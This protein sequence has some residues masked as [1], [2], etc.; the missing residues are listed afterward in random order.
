[1][2]KIDIDKLLHQRII[3]KC[4]PLYEDGYFPQ[5]ASESMKQ[6]ELAI[7]EKT[8]IGEKLFGVRLVNQVFGAGKSIKL[9]IPLGDEL[10]EQAKSLFKGAFSYYRNYAAHDGSKIDEIICIRVMVLAS[11]LLDLIG[12]SSISFTEIGGVEGLIKQGIFDDETQIADLV[13][14]LSSQ[15]FV[16]ETYDGMFK[17]LAIGGYPD[18]QYQAVFDLDFVELRSK[19]ENHEFPEDPMDF[20]KIEWFELTPMGRKVLNQIRKSSS[21]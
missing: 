11:E 6:V 15:V 17:D 10:Q 20:D 12:A 21:A 14:L 13:S 3:Y 19:I 1:M 16:D 4:K 9:K 7:K 2:T 18:S 5:A 8:G